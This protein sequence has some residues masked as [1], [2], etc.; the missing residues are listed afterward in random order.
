[1][2]SLQPKGEKMRRA[3][4]WISEVKMVEKSAPI[5]ALIERAA[6]RFN[7]SPKEGEFLRNFYEQAE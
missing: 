2:E 3:I 6:L 7:L 1:M 4:K 5:S